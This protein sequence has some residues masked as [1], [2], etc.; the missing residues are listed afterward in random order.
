[1]RPLITALLL[2][3]CL[4]HKDFMDTVPDDFDD[5]LLLR[6]REAPQE[7]DFPTETQKV[8]LMYKFESEPEFQTRGNVVLTKNQN[9]G[10]IVGVSLEEGPA[11]SDIEARFKTLPRDSF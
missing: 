11:P 9:N 7:I 4:A 3:S 6:S 10:Q 2:S 5:S 1:M 8:G